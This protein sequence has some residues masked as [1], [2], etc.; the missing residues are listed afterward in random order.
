MCQ[1]L[2]KDVVSALKEL[3]VFGRRADMKQIY[4]FPCTG[5]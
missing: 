4:T 3:L 1:T 2:L 5:Y